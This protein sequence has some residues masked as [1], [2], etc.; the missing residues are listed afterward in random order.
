VTALLGR[1]DERQDLLGAQ[2]VDLRRAAHPRSL[3]DISRVARQPVDLHRPLEDR[4][5]ADEVLLT[6]PIGA[7]VAAHPELDVLRGDRLDLAIAKL[8]DEDADHVAVVAHRRGLAVADVLA[9]GEPLLRGVAEGLAGLH[10]PRERP[11]ASLGQQLVQMGRRLRLGEVTIGR[12]GLL[13]PGWTEP[14]LLLPTI[15]QPVLR[16]PDAAAF[17][18]ALKDVSRDWARLRRA[19]LPPIVACFRDK[20][21]TKFRDCA[22]THLANMAI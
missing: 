11:L 14:L 17:S 19:H 9:V 18:L 21:G 7:A 3:D 15:W 20:F 16:V 22:N 2:H 6:G 5:E 4:A 1:P 13:R 12:R 8:A 10:H